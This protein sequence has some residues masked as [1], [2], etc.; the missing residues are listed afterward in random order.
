MISLLLA[1]AFTFTA[2][3]TGVEKGTP[4][5]FLIGGPNTDRDYETMFLLEDSVDIFLKGLEKAGFPKG[6]PTDPRVCQ[7]WPVGAVVRIEPDFLSFVDREFPDGLAAA[8][9]VF[10]GGTRLSS[11]FPD[12]A[13]NMPAAVMSFYSLAQSPFVYDGIYE[14]G[15]VYGSHK[16][17][18]QLKKGQR[19]KFTLTCDPLTLPQSLEIV[20]DKNNV[21]QHLDKIRELS[22][23]REISVRAGFSGDLS[24]YEATAIANALALLDSP[25]IKVNG[26]RDGDLFYRAFLPLVKWRSRQERLTQPF[27]IYLEKLSRIL[28]IEEDWSVEGNDP[29]LTEREITYEGMRQHPKTDTVFFYVTKETP[30]KRVQE[31]LGKL[32]KSVVNHYVV[33]E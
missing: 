29:K 22:G 8:P 7:L 25:R 4:L 32:P 31:A 16:A 17:K 5:E 23:K 18:V 13:T 33:C 3:A 10:T 12:A 21:R 11:G 1:A 28:F 19:V 14:Q 26:R 15:V 6:V 20:F 24:V 30:V 27:E 9:F 2:T